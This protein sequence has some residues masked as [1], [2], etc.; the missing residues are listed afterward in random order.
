MWELDFKSWK[1][2]RAPDEM[3]LRAIF[4]F[5]FFVFLGGLLVFGLEVGAGG[6]RDE[7]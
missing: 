2:K 1:L 4:V 3:D 7:G 5:L 6:C